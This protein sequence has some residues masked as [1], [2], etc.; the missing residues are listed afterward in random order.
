MTDESLE[1]H[2]ETCKVLCPVVRIHDTVMEIHQASLVIS[3]YFL[4]DKIHE[5]AGD[6]LEAKAHDASSRPA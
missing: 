6:D 1:Y 2:T 3:Q 5:S 4:P